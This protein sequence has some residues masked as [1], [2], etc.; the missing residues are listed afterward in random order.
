MQFNPVSPRLSQDQAASLQDPPQQQTEVV[1]SA[2]DTAIFLG[3]NEQ[4][5]VTV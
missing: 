5:F 3:L 4:Q 2:P 1:V